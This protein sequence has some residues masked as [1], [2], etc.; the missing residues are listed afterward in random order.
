Y[1][2]S[3][4]CGVREFFLKTIAM[5]APLAERLKD[6]ELVSD[7]EATGNFSYECTLANG[8]NFL[9]IGDAYAFVDPMFSTGVLLAMHSGI[10]A[11]TAISTCL[12]EPAKAA[13]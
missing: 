8:E 12:R 9:M 5:C 6:A 7:V 1:L 13:R 3:R 2:K 4:T 10:E 11:A